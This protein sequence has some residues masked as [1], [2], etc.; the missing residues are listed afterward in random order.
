VDSAIVRITR[1]AAPEVGTDRDAL[2]RLVD[3]A[4]AERRKTLASAVRRLGLDADDLREDLA[5]SGVDLS[6]R[7][8]DTGLFGFAALTEA[9]LARGWRP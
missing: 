1:R 5:G 3:E 7:A 8:E 2:F 4:F 6:A 9:L